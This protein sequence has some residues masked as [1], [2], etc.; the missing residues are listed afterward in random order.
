MRGQVR[1]TA[2]SMT[3]SPLLSAIMCYYNCYMYYNMSMRAGA[4]CAVVI[5]HDRCFLDH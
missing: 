1:T 5:S 2:T 3:A 4:S